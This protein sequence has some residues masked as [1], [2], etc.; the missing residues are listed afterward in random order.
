MSRVAFEKLGHFHKAVGN[1]IFGWAFVSTIKG[2]PYFDTGDGVHSDHIPAESIVP[3]SKAFMNASRVGLDMHRGEQVAEVVYSYPMTDDIMRGNEITSEKQGLMIGWDTDDEDLIAK[4]AAGERIGFSIGGLVKSY[5]IVD[6][7][8]NV[9]ESISVGKRRG[10]G[11]VRQGTP[12]RFGK[13]AGYDGSD[14]R[15]L[16]RVFREWELGEISLVD[17]PMQEPALV[18]VVKGKIKP[19]KKIRTLARAYAKGSVLTSSTDGHQ[20]VIDPSACDSSGA[21]C[22]SWSTSEGSEYGHDHAWVRN[23]ETGAIE[24]AENEGH[25]HTVEAVANPAVPP[26][27]GA[28]IVTT[29]RA[30]NLP[31]AASASSVKATKEPTDMDPKDKQIADL[32]AA[33]ESLTKSLESARRLATL[34]DSQRSHYGKLSIDDQAAFLAKSSLE[35]DQVVKAALDADPVHY[36][37]KSGRVFRASERELGDMAKRMDD[38]DL[39]LAKAREERDIATHKAFAKASLANLPLNADKGDDVALVKAIHSIDDKDGQRTR[40]LTALKGADAIAAEGGT[41][42]G[43]EETPEET[44]TGEDNTTP[45]DPA[46]NPTT[47]TG[48][49][50]NTARVELQKMADALAT[51]ESIHPAIAKSRLLKSN[52]KAKQLYAKAQSWDRQHRN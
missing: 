40:I 29:M 38:Q 17:Y 33:K 2:E 43:G 4:V 36:T 22:T 26:Q 14:G 23:T 16:L 50:V 10:P 28:V 45:D 24:I 8:G 47:K 30:E 19:F 41:P 3:V 18:G 25:T 42:Q 15:M 9:V 12:I 34:T 32:T 6:V 21:G 1:T 52:E 27:G 7:N 48:G 44:P 31:R 13:V 5:D 51:K 11:G 39:E 20:H 46:V 49:K 37:A 35:R